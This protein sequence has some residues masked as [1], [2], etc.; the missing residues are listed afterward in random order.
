MLGEL[1]GR[2]LD[3][4]GREVWVKWNI[5]L[6]CGLLCMELKRVKTKLSP[7][8]VGKMKDNTQHLFRL[9][10]TINYHQCNFLLYFYVACLNKEEFKKRRGKGTELESV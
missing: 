7:F 4:S 9:N 8:T 1:S 2:V 5:K 6:G 3:C 10:L